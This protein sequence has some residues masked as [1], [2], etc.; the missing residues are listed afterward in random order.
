MSLELLKQIAGYWNVKFKARNV[1]HITTD[2][3]IEH[4]QGPFAIGMSDEQDVFPAT[5]CWLKGAGGKDGR[6][7]YFRLNKD[8]TLELHYFGPMYTKEY[9][10]LEDYYGI[11][12]IGT[13]KPE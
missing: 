10:G 13:R 7:L 9:E 6:Y 3:R 8:D 2:G 11:K 5:D 12:G 1:Y 4:K